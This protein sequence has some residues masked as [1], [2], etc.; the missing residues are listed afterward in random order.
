MEIKPIKDILAIPK[1]DL[2]LMVLSDNPASFLSFGIKAHQNGSYN[3]FM[4]MIEPGRF[5]SQDLM[6]HSVPAEKYFGNRLKMWHCPSWTNPERLRLTLLVLR[7]LK[8]PWY[9]RLYDWPQILGFMVGVRGLQLPW[10]K[11]CSDHVDYLAAVD[12][13]WQVNQHFSPPEINRIF[14]QIGKYEV[15]NYYDPDIEER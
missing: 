14:K 11:I 5:A 6:Y 7:A 1:E 8:E 2:P 13:L 10:R 9:K 4:W 3:H 12:P 15:Y